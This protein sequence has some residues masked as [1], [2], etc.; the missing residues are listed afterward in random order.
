MD[1]KSRSSKDQQVERE[2]AAQYRDSIDK[3]NRSQDRDIERALS[4]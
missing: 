3:I 2:S 4:R 1:D